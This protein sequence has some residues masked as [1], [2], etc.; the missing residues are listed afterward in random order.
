M[1]TNELNGLLLA[2]EERVRRSQQEPVEQAFFNPK[3]NDKG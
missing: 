1:M 2:Y 3:E